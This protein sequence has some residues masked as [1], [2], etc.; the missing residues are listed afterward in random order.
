[1]AARELRADAGQHGCCKPLHLCGHTRP[2]PRAAASSES[3]AD[4]LFVN[5]P[6]ISA[7]PSCLHQLC[8]HG[9]R[10]LP[11]PV[12]SCPLGID[13][14]SRSPQAAPSCSELCAQHGDSTAHCQCVN[15]SSSR[16]APARP[17]G[18]RTGER[19]SARAKPCQALARRQARSERGRAG[20]GVPGDGAGRR[21][22]A[23]SECAA[24]AARR[25]SGRQREWGR[26][27]RGKC[28]KE[29]AGERGA[30]D[31][32][33]ANMCAEHVWAACTCQDDVSWV[34]CGCNLARVRC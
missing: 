18:H 16:L 33:S 17:A 12:A 32:A 30:S 25:R 28:Q 27:Q 21:R 29:R 31:V 24:D 7:Q 26:R 4:G 1:V 13:A 14:R 3:G 6:M 11:L 8:E 22:H 5:W 10:K 34:A 15:R 2:H 19:R 9:S 20:R 23:A